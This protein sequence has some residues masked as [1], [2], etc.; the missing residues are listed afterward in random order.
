[1]KILSLSRQS[2]GNQRID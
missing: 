2:A 1:V